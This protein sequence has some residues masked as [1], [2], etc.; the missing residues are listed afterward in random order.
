MATIT[1]DCLFDKFATALQDETHVR[2]KQVEF[3][4]WLNAGQ[5][6]IAAVKPEVSVSRS[7]VALSAG[8]K[9]TIPANGLSLVDVTRNMGTDG[10]TDGAAIMPLP[11]A[12]LDQAYA[13]WHNLTSST[14]S[15]FCYDLREPKTY[16][17]YPAQPTPATQYVEII[18]TVT[19]ANVDG[20]SD[21][22][23]IDDEYEGAL[24]DYCLYRALIKDAEDATQLK[25]AE[26]HEQS[27]L[28]ALGLQTQADIAMAPKGDEPC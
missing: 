16:W 21:A 8:T 17:I 25:R 18:V 27:F 11:R 12:V 15:F 20:L 23:S 5:R 4:A 9:Q 22:I 3:F 14:V 24:L 7:S 28:R 13:D 19:P 1:A 10:S 6:A 26:M 2:W